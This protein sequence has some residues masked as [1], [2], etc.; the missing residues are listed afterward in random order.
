MATASQIT[1]MREISAAGDRERTGALD[2]EWDGAKASLF[3]IFGH[4]NHVEFETADGRKLVGGDALN[5]MVQELPNDFHVA[6]WRRA[7]VTDDTVRCTAEDLMFLFRRD[8]SK[9]ATRTL[10]HQEPPPVVETPPPPPPP[11]LRLESPAAVGAGAGAPGAD[12]G[13]VASSTAAAGAAGGADPAGTRVSGADEIP[14][15]LEGFPLLPHGQ[16]LFSDAA[17]NVTNLEAAIPHLPD[18]LI[19]LTCGDRRGAAIVVRGAVTDAVCVGSTGG[20]LGDDAA[21]ELFNTTDGTLAAHRL[22]DA[23][24]AEALPVLWRSPRA[25]APVPGQWINPDGFVAGVRAAGYTCALLVSESKEP[26]VALFNGGDLVAVYTAARP[27]PLNTLAA[28][29]QLLRASGA[30]ATLVGVP[31]SAG[32]EPEIGGTSFPLVM[33]S[34]LEPWLGAVES[35]TVD[36]APAPEQAP[37][38]EPALAVVE[39]LPADHAANDGAAAVA[40]HTAPPAPPETAAWGVRGRGRPAEQPA[41]PEPPAF[42]FGSIDEGRFGYQPA[43]FV[44]PDA[45]EPSEAATASGVSQAAETEPSAPLATLGAMGDDTEF[46]PTRVDV[47]IEG[48]RTELIGIAN[49]W[50]GEADAGQVAAVVL[51]ARPGVD[52]FVS[53]IKNIASMEIPDHEHAVVRAMAR[54]MH[55]R[56]AEVL[57]GV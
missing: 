55:F 45:V 47:D 20:H 8:P 31:A 17:S 51:A 53:A 40:D 24:V 2:V 11:D 54:E 42:T 44:L 13:V 22:D 43:V 39:Q 16:A 4:A 57:C 37:P 7:M 28:V 27:A 32:R 19:L 3:F 50:L 48:L 26:G 6:P 38:A 41:E 56:A 10:G 25:C 35:P 21:R 49:V 5:A 29:R 52:D 30:R 9:N 23:A 36:Q 18:S 33:P 1:M 46:V 14:F 12:V 34:A 15:D